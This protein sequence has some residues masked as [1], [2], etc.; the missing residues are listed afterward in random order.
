MAFCMYMACNGDEYIQHVLIHG[1]HVLIHPI[2]PHPWVPVMCLDLFFQ[3]I[4]IHG[5]TS[6][7]LL[8]TS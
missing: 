3:Y 7:K 1:Q 6:Q 5:N 8:N 2:L 4:S